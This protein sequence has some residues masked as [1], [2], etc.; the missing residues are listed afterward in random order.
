MRIDVLTLFPQACEPFFGCSI[1]GRARKAGLVEVVCTNIRDFATDKH[2][3]VDDTPFGGGPGML[4]AAPPVFD[5]VE[6]VEAADSRHATRVLLTP[7][8]CRL[9]QRLAT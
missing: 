5:A 2:R 4:M 3:S 9:D 7:P 8:G 6:R 1:I